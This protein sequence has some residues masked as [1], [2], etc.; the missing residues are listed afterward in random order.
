MTLLIPPFKSL[1]EPKGWGHV[2][3]RRT[4]GIR[5]T[6]VGETYGFPTLFGSISYTKDKAPI[7]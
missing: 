5:R 3:R 4:A 2:R 6:H 7:R 1:A